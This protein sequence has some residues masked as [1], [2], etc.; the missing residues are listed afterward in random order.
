MKGDVNKSL[1][2]DISYCTNAATF[3]NKKDLP[4][5]PEPVRNMNTGA[6][7]SLLCNI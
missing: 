4:V 7:S 1:S 2:I 6:C 5:P 3:S